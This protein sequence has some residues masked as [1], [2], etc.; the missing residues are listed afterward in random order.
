LIAV[1]FYF[2]DTE[3]KYKDGQGT[4]A[5]VLG[6]NYRFILACEI[7]PINDFMAFYVPSN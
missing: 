3:N 2:S 1:S 7:I 6:N 4:V 5:S